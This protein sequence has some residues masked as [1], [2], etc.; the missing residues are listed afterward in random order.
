MAQH[1]E[2][3]GELAQIDHATN[4]SAVGNRE[5]TIERNDESTIPYIAAAG[6][7]ALSLTLNGCPATTAIKALSPTLDPDSG[8]RHE[9]LALEVAIAR[10]TDARSTTSLVERAMLSAANAHATQTRK[11]EPI[12]YIAHPLAVAMHLAA[13]HAD[14]S[15]VAAA[16]VH[17]VV[18]DTEWSEEELA[19][20]LGPNSAETMEFVRFATEPP[21]SIGW[22]ERKEAIVAKLADA[23]TEQRALVIADKAHNLRSLIRALRRDGETAWGVLRHGR[24]GQSWFAHA[25]A[26]TIR[27]ESGEPFESYAA[28]VR[29]AV[30]S[31]WLATR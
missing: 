26:K 13:A 18:E 29:D 4:R 15:L 10:L 2:T 20:A 16:L 21:K 28:S 30:K 14:E 3:L 8:G 19:H 11:G 27:A 25:I 22:R 5:R 31:G 12:P 9:L 24:A 1:E 17:D 23:T 6:S 7:A